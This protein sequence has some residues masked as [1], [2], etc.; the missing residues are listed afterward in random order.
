MSKELMDK[1]KGKKKVHEMWKKD[2]STWEEY[3]NVVRACRDAMRKAKALLELNLA[4]EV[5]DNKKEFFLKYVNSKRKT[6]EN[7]GPLLN[8]VGALVTGD[9]EKAEILNASVASVFIAK[10]SPQESQTLD[11]RER[12][13]VKVDCWLRWIWSESI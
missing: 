3:R 2:L 9:T 4:K 13:R 12:V 5:Y 8:E 7:V 10:T 1:L 6:R 11:I